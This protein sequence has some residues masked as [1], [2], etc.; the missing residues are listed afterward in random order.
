MESK[1][2]SEEF[3]HLSEI[4]I[5]V[6]GLCGGLGD[7]YAR[8]AAAHAM[9]DA[10]AKYIPESHSYLHGEKSSLWGFIPVGFRRQVVDD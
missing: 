10:I 1:V 4:V 8:N 6:A 3:V 7:K 5:A 2:V 9:H